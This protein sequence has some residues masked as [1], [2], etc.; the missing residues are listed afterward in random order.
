MKK[1]IKERVRKCRARKAAKG[2]RPISVWL[3]PQT[4][5]MLDAIRKHYGKSKR[6]KNAP[7][8]A[9]AIDSL[10]QSIIIK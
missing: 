1:S 8:V 6:G 4:V 7:L 3:E 10:Y 2:G 5:L 9:K